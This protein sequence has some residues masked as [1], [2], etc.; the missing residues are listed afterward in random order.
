MA[1]ATCTTQEATNRLLHVGIALF[2]FHTSNQ[3]RPSALS[4]LNLL[5]QHHKTGRAFEEL[6]SI[7]AVSG[8]PFG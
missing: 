7:V 1:Y 3:Q 2:R 4:E 8:F 6:A 5:S